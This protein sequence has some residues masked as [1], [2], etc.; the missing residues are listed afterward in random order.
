MKLKDRIKSN[1]DDFDMES[2]LL[3][4][5]FRESGGDP[6]KANGLYQTLKPFRDQY[7]K[8]TGQTITEESLKDIEVATAVVVYMTEWNRRN[9]ERNTGRL[10]TVKET[11][12]MH[13]FGPTGGRRLAEAGEGELVKDLIAPWAMKANSYI[14]PTYTKQDLIEHLDRAGER[15]DNEARFSKRQAVLKELGYYSGD[16]DALE[17]ENTSRAERI[18]MSKFNMDDLEQLDEF[19]ENYF[20]LSYED[21][22]QYSLTGLPV[23]DMYPDNRGM[24]DIAIR[25]VLGEYRDN[26]GNPVTT[27]ERIQARQ[28]L[29]INPRTENVE[30]IDYSKQYGTFGI[31][32]PIHTEQDTYGPIYQST[33][34]I[35]T[36]E[37]YLEGL[38]LD[39]FTESELRDMSLYVGVPQ[40]ELDRIVSTPEGYRLE[41]EYQDQILPPL[42]D[43]QG[44]WQG[45]YTEPYS[46]PYET[47]AELIKSEMHQ[48]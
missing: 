31:E 13:H 10:P 45:L 36:Q 48:E 17:G 40:E 21:R 15:A 24:Y 7:K 34:P 23:S 12:Y 39:D 8:L 5:V 1:E 4:V 26:G 18:F 46:Q 14:K 28:K 3:N 35:V 6:T 43:E 9:F 38:N 29:G 33:A 37:E 27:I 41:A 30:A 47:E 2:Y 32:V 22:A 25:K 19:V 16:V 42:Y 44:N 20:D 11:Y